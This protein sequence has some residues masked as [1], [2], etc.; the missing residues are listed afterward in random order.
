MNSGLNSGPPLGKGVEVAVQL[1]GQL[2]KFFE[3]AFGLRNFGFFLA[4]IQ[5]ARRAPPGERA[6]DPDGSLPP[7][8]LQD[9]HGRGGARRRGRRQARTPLR[10]YEAQPSPRGHAPHHLFPVQPLR[11]Q[12]SQRS[13]FP[14][15]IFIVFCSETMFGVSALFG[16]IT[17]SSPNDPHSGVFVC[18]SRRIQEPK[19]ESF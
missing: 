12:T 3:G 4:R 17:F 11:W 18:Q 1:D 10:G 13:L 15:I 14:A 7:R 5:V 16:L 8:G 9:R 19:T 2:V 6:A